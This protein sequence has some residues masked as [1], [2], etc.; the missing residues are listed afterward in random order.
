M[1]KIVSLLLFLSVLPL[2]LSAQDRKIYVKSFDADILELRAKTDPVYDKNKIPASMVSIFLTT[3]DSLVFKGNI[4]RTVTGGPGEWIAYI[5]AGTEWL[6]VAAEGCARP[7]MG[8]YM[9]AK[10][11]S[12]A[13]YWRALSEGTSMFTLLRSA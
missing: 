5:P 10:F 3:K 11:F 6:E 9:D 8:A 4:L 7:F 12:G 2:A 13:K 1:K